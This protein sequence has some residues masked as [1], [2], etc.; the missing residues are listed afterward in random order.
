ML[1]APPYSA[2]LNQEIL[3]GECADY[4]FLP[5]RSYTRRVQDCRVS[6]LSSGEDLDD[7]FDGLVGAVIGGFEAAGRSRIKIHDTRVIRLLEVPLHGGTHVGG[8]TTQQVHHVVLTTF[9]ISERAYGLN[10]LRYDLRKLKG[11]GLLERDGSRYAYRLTS[12]GVQVA[13]LF[14]FF[15]KRL[16]GPLANSRFHHRPDQGEVGVHVEPLRLETG[17][18]AGDGLEGLANCIEMVQGLTQAEVF[19]IVGTRFIAQECRELFVLLEEGVPEV[20]AEDMMAVRDLIDHSSEFTAVPAGKTGAEDRRYL[21]GGKPP[22]AEFATALEQVV[23]RKVS[24]EDEVATILDLR[25]GIE[26]RQIE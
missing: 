24:L 21:V 8:W 22:Q 5:D 11:H 20:G 13:V 10:Q 6:A 17:E 16:C 3:F 12:K 15:H 7:I 23:D 4:R 25:D 9:H 1:T 2:H 18:A 26:A 14:L 19:E